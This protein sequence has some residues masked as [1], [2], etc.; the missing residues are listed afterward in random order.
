MILLSSLSIVTPEIGLVFWATLIF[1]TLW[2]ILGKKAFKPISNAL[3][4]R[5]KSISEAIAQAEKTR[6]EM[7]QMQADN[8]NALQEAR[9]HATKI[10]NDA[11]DKGN[12]MVEEAQNKARLDAKRIMDDALA[13][14][15][16]QKVAAIRDVKNSLG[17]LT[18]DMAAKVLSREL[19]DKQ[20][21]E[22]YV[23]AEIDKI[24]LN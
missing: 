12:Q 14:I 10:I 16:A 17:Q 22:S 21:Q 6:Q 7:A 3:E 15:E 4:I 9:E 19:S 23:N 11:K 2:I 13:G 5:N 24:N 1:V 18:V 20:A 8:A